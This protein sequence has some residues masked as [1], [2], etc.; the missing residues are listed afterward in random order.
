MKQKTICNFTVLSSKKVDELEAVL[1]EMKHEKSG[2]RLVWLDRREENKTFAVAFQTQ[3]WDDTGV[4]HILE[5]SVLCGSEKYPVKE[6][7]VELLKSSLNTFLNAMT[8][9][10]KTMYPFSTRNDQDFVNL[11]RVYMDAVL[12]PAIHQKPEIFGQEG[13]H[14]ELDE[15]GRPSYKGVVFNEMKGAFASPDSLMEYELNR[16]LFPDTCYRFESGGHPE[17][18]PEL[19]YE[20]FAA[21]HKRLYHP[22]NAYFFL[23]GDLDMEK[24]L[25]ILD[26]EYLGEY[27]AAPGPGEIPVQQPVDGGE[28]EV[29]YELSPQ[30][31]PAEKARLAEGFVVCSYEDREEA[32]A[33]QVLSDVL[34]GDNQAPLTRRLLESGLAKEARFSLYESVR[35]PWIWLEARDMDAGRASEVMEAMHGELARLAEEGLDHRRILA[36]LDNMEFQARQRDYGR[37]PQ[38]LVFGMQVL[39]SWLYGGAPEE[40]LSVGG[41]FDGLRAKVEQGYFESLLERGLLHNSHQCR[42]LMRP[43]HTLGEERQKEEAKRLEAAKSTWSPEDEAKIRARQESIELWQNTPDTPEQLATIPMLK[44]E[45]IPK[46]PEPLPLEEAE[47]HGIPLLRHTLPTGGI[48][49]LN[50]YFALDDLSP[51]ELTQAAFL[52]RLL[53]SLETENRDL[54]RLQREMRSLF[55]QMAFHVEAYGHRDDPARCR[56]FLCAFG[57]ILDSKLQEALELLGELLRETKWNDPKRVRE[58]VC[59]Q[60]AAFA[61][62][63]VMSGHMTALNR[64]LACCSA[65]GVVAE[66]TG[67]VEYFHWLRD[68]EQNFEE[69]FP[70]LAEELEALAGRIFCKKRLTLSATSSNPQAEDAAGAAFS[71]RLPEG[72]F[73]MPEEPAVRPWGIRREGIAAPADVS[74]AGLCGA[75]PHA[76]TGQASVMGKAA[77]LAY[78]WNAVRVQGGA[79]GVGMLLW[80]SGLGGFYSYRDPSA[81]RTL[82]CYAATAD[83]LRNA[84]EMDLT[85][86]IIGAVADSDP[87]LTPRLRGKTADMRH[88][89]GITQED[90][91]RERREILSTKPEDLVR[92]APEVERLAKEGAVCV[93]GSRRQIE[94]CGEKLDAVTEL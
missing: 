80:N 68:L 72:A 92:L 43:S 57:S 90:L 16:R 13:W 75:L 86:M 21:A 62:Q 66:H 2:A 17:H 70:A 36:T 41:L 83:F 11:L 15:N 14:Y 48:S 20:A 60:R 87:L 77:S 8:F 67:G 71:A 33:W 18:I 76:K 50:L 51:Q 79:Y 29:F 49:Y 4:F 78:L 58:L 89:R 6:P 1:Y 27:Q 81:A 59:Q 5:H 3:P 45:E 52:A 46:E 82:D 25:G 42:V 30:E 35:Q 39:D 73:R 91:C 26:R 28:G 34:C 9:P 85:G 10:D 74:F 47:T 84:G 31:D 7:F 56:A 44:L 93:L 65:G 63:L 37:M 23:D 88:W 61:E 94:A 54:D 38:G 53:G 55:G 69:R 32:T 12:R 22:S 19:T 40:N 24:I 64:T